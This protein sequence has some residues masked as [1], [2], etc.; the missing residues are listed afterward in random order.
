[1]T[2]KLVTDDRGS[3][4][5][6]NDFVLRSIVQRCYWIRNHQAGFVRA[7]HG[8]KYE[9]KY[10]TVLTGTAMIAA[11]QI[12][13][14]ITPSPDA[15]IVRYT[16][17]GHLPQVLHIPAGYANGIKTLTSDALV[18]VFS[19]A[20]VDES[21]EDDIRFPSRLWDPWGVTER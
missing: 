14:W 15:P 6:V 17:S 21:T 20:T 8:H 2:G 19:T 3:V 10:V 1:M 18:M 13:N 12:D 5:F 7:W 9:S 16:L 11:V 4:G